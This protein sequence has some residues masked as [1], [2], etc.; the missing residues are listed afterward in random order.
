MSISFLSRAGAFEAP[1]IQYA[2]LRDNVLHHIDAGQ[3]T[4]RFQELYRIGECLGGA[5]VKVSAVRLREQV[6]QAQLLCQLPIEKLA[7]SARTKAVISMDVELPIGPPTRIIG[8][9]LNMPWIAEERN[10]LGDVFGQ[11]V[12]KL[13]QITEG[14][15]ESDLVEI[16]DS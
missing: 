12:R 9:G 2:L 7:V 4:P 15:T 16:V 13:L 14:T 5:T 1:W 8:I 11:I 3:M 10:T 6:Q